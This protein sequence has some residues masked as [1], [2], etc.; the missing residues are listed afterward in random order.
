[1]R[2]TKKPITYRGVQEAIRKF[3]SEHG[4]EPT[5]RDFDRCQYLPSARTLQR[6]FGGMTAVR[7]DMG[8][9]ARYNSGEYR[10]KTMK[11]VLA[12]T[13][14]Y[15][16]EIFEKLY[17]RYHDWENF[18]TTVDRAVAYQKIVSKDGVWSE[19]RCDVMIHNQER[20]H[21]EF[22]DM[23]FP[24][25]MHSFGGCVGVKRRKLE[26]FPVRVH[27]TDTFNVTFVCMNPA[28]TQEMIDSRNINSGGY[29]VVSYQT[30]MEEWLS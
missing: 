3:I 17:K 22:F 24:S 28:I 12:R 21:Y 6:R 4:R 8:I 29:R 19:Q 11:R 16:M 7:Q 13:R 15:E 27:E 9:K 5:H 1:M 26:R 2:Q 23:F 30:F 18:S 10:R 25:D 14:Q 20:G